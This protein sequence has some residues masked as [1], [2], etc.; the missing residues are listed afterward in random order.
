MIAFLVP[1]AFLSGILYEIYV[2]LISQGETA[3]ILVAISVFVFVM[4]SLHYGNK[5]ITE[6]FG[7]RKLHT[8]KDHI[9]LIFWGLVD[10]IC[11]FTTLVLISCIT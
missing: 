7:W 9:L 4:I 3:V 5:M 11:G 1:I 8:L 6:T 10:I 2:I